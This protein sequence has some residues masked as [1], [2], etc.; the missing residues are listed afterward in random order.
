MFMR[1]AWM[2]I[3]ISIKDICIEPNKTFAHNLP[4]KHRKGNKVVPVLNYLSTTK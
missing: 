4:L 3:H 2:K 1:A